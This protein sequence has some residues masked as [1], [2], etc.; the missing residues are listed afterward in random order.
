MDNKKEQLFRYF[1]LGVFAL[2][3]YQIVRIFSVFITPI[4]TAVV[5]AMIFYPLHKWF[6]K[7]LH[8]PA[9]SSILSTL[10]VVM[11]MVVPLFIL[12]LTVAEQAG[13]VYPE[14]KGWIDQAAG[15]ERPLSS[16]LPERAREFW[17]NLREKL[18]LQDLNVKEFFLQRLRESSQELTTIGASVLKNAVFFFLNV[19][20][21]TF[22]IFF[23]FKDG[24]RAIEWFI[25]LIPMEADHKSHIADTLYTTFNAVIRGLF[26]TA[27]AQGILA[28]IGFA[29]AGVKFAVILGLLTTFLAIF[30]FGGAAAVWIPA[31]LYLYWQG[32]TGSAIF[33]GVWGL[34]VV[35]TI[36]N[37]LKPI[38][39][40][41]KA[42]LPLLLLFFGILGGIKLYGFLGVLLGP[43][44]IACAMAFIRIYREEFQPHK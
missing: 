40:G 33:L 6:L 16:L 5:L 15:G 38:L 17:M 13:Q 31:T 29:I 39:I 18:K 35:S 19:L 21:L 7:K 28:G 30:P 8:S 10:A 36:D 24:K 41:G 2:I 32:F 34:L 25:E 11:L 44:F 23:L 22:T 26:L 4:L 9:A 20:I 3:L 37:F 43:L 42:K 14:V 27:A 12:S 1:F